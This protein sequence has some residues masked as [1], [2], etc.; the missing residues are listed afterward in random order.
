MVSVMPPASNSLGLAG[1]ITS[2][3][4]VVTCG[5]L[6]PMGLIL[7]LVGLVRRP[8]GF[9]LAG[10]IIGALG[11]AWLV[12]AG[13]TMVLA[14]VGIGKT[15]GMLRDYSLVLQT[16]QSARA[17]IESHQKSTGALPTADQAPKLIG[18]LRDPWGNAL[19]YE[20]RGESFTLTSSGPDAQAGTADDIELTREMLEAAARRPA[21]APTVER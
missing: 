5:V 19:A 15:A 16:A 17:A 10:A 21:T 20:P 6:A 14:A 3:V 7:S 8:R 13:L 2:L 18:E 4:G 11:T 12:I 9:A 1:F